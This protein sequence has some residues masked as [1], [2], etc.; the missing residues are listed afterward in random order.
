M[1]KVKVGLLA[2]I[3]TALI[4]ALAIAGI[5]TR[6]N[7]KFVSPL[8]TSFSLYAFENKKE[9]AYMVYGFLPYWSLPDIEYLQP[10][11]LTDTVMELFKLMN[12]VTQ[13]GVTAQL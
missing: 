4:A 3:P 8:G 6:N 5:T 1:S 12:R 11:K 2:L 9:S 13:I 7:Q 10:D